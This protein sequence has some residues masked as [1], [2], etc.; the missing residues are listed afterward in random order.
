MASAAGAA[1]CSLVHLIICVRASFRPRAA[2]AR[3]ARLV[4]G[5]SLRGSPKANVVTL[6][7]FV[8]HV[9]SEISRWRRKER[10]T[11]G[12]KIAHFHNR[13]TDQRHSEDTY[14]FQSLVLSF[15]CMSSNP[16]SYSIINPCDKRKSCIKWIKGLQHNSVGRAVSAGYD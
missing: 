7:S 13:V 15:C 10:G 11:V 3:T 9:T 16:G 6:P 14:L 12:K 2:A 5:R 4:T 8:S 1:V